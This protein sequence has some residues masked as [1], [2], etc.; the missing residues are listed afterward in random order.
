MNFKLIYITCQDKAEAKKIGR[1]LVEGRLAACVNI[2]DNMESLYWWE[3]KLEEGKETVIIA[4][5]RA[6][7]V[8]QVVKKVKELH[9]YDNPCV[10]ALPIEAG[11]LDYLAWLEK[12]T[13]GE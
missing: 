13:K 7:L 4:K 3:G 5:T 12:E 2:L 9:S 10:V 11:S 6:S 8:E 1:A